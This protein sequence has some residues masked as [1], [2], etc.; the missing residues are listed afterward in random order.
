MIFDACN[1]RENAK[2]ILYIYIYQCADK[3]VIKSY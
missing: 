1:Q 2:I 3:L